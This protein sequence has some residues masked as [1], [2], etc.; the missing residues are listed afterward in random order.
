MK[1]LNDDLD[2]ANADKQV[3]EAFLG[4]PSKQIFKTD[5]RIYRIVSLKDV[6]YRDGTR[7]GNALFQ[8]PWWIPKDTFHTITSRANR[9]KQPLNAVA[10]SGLA[11]TREFNPHM[12]W[13]AV[14]RMKE[15]A[16]GWTGRTA[17]QPEF[18]D[19]REV[20]LIGGLVQIWL[21]GLAAGEQDYSSRYAFIEYFGPF[22]A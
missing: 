9:L 15:P 21:P 1:I 2:F 11:V 14:V 22:D 18:K 5:D 17:H 19:K 13:I 6:V 12:D 7:G 16:Y 4:P 20:L 3:R 8:S 10:R